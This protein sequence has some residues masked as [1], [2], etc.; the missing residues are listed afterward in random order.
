[1][2][3]DKHLYQH[4][5][6]FIIGFFLLALL[7]FWP[8]YY[9]RIGADMEVRFHTHGLAMTTWCVLLIVQALLIRFKKFS[10]HRLIGKVS[11]V[12]FP[13]II[14][15]TLNLIHHQFQDAGPLANI[16]LA[17]IA[18][19]VNATLV[20]AILYG[21]AI[22][23][24][25]KPLVH[26]RY[27]I[28]T[29]FPMV[30]PVTDRLIYRHYRPLLEYVPTI[31]GYTMAPAV[32]FLLAD[33]ILLALVIWDWRTRKEPGPFAVALVLLLI[34]HASVLYFYDSSIWRAFAEWFLRLPLS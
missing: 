6:F 17:N 27:M 33:L 25:K 13:L 29:V 11:Y 30:T 32:G 2:R 31:D 3:L 26:A 20:L 28:C 14:A 9:S 34:Y 7:A 24:Q 5:A 23:Y 4:S 16:H 10:I 12:I 15:A 21:L 8:S 22:Y 18:L 19:M 1:M